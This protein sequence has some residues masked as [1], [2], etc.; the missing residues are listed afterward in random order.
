MAIVVCGWILHV[1]GHLQDDPLTEALDPGQ[2][3]PERCDIGHDVND[4]KIL[5]WIARRVGI[6]GSVWIASARILARS[7]RLRG[8]DERVAVE[9]A[10]A[11]LYRN[12]PADADQLR[13]RPLHKL[14]ERIVVALPVSTAALWGVYLLTPL[15][16]GD[17][18]WRPEIWSGTIVLTTHYLEEAQ[19]RADRIGLMHKGVF[20]RE[21]TVSEL[22]RA[23]PATIRFALPSTAPEPP[24]TAERQG[25]GSFLIETLGLQ[26]DLHLLLGWA[27]DHAVEL[28]DLAAGPT[29][30]DDV[31]R[32]IGS[33]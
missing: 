11:E 17:M 15:A 33:D 30:L 26:K 24:L 5:K 21:G 25:D 7:G 1:F 32:S 2:V 19:Q 23:L 22:T 16:T 29:R 12:G 4:I 6:A 20:H 3:L 27:Q 9:N 18:A 31:F 8:R 10:D 13:E 14:R 28:R